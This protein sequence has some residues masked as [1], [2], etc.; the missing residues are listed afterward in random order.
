MGPPSPSSASDDVTQS[1]TASLAISG[2]AARRGAQTHSGCQREHAAQPALQRRLRFCRPQETQEAATA[3]T[4]NATV[5]LF[6]PPPPVLLLL[7]VSISHGTST[8]SPTSTCRN[9]CA[10]G[11]AQA[12]GRRRRPRPRPR[13]SPSCWWSNRPRKSTEAT[14]HSLFLRRVLP[15]PLACGL[16]SQARAGKRARCACPRRPPAQCCL[17]RRACRGSRACALLFISRLSSRPALSLSLSLSRSL[18]P[19]ATVCLARPALLYPA[20]SPGPAQ[21]QGT[22]PLSSF[23]PLSLPPLRPGSFF[24]S[25]SPAPRRSRPGAAA[26][27]ASLLLAPAARLASRAAPIPA[28]SAVFQCH[29]DDAP[30]PRPDTNADGATGACAARSR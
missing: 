27:P 23:C 16:S 6:S 3:D 9:M 7:P 18:S 13:P 29:P 24:A 5:T 8:L 17:R 1:A 20:G 25:P 30:P 21:R 28:A 26:Q 19:R 2:R 14:P 4:A 10:R 12:R 11:R 22:R 15:L